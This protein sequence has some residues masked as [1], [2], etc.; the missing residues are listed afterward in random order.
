[1]D[2]NKSE[3]ETWKKIAD[4]LAEECTMFKKIQQIDLDNE[5]SN[6]LVYMTKEEVLDWAKREVQNGNNSSCSN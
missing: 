2:S 5:Y 6:G 4:I 1:M 3:L